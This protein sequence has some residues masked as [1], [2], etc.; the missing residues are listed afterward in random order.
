[1]SKDEYKRKIL[2]I[3]K[4]ELY[5]NGQVY[6]DAKLTEI[7]EAKLREFIKKAKD[8]RKLDIDDSIS[9]KK[10]LVK[11]KL[12]KGGNLT[13]SAVLLF[14]RNPQEFFIQSG[15]KCIRFKGMD[16]TGEMLDFKEIEGNLFSVIEEVENFVFKNIALKAWIEEGKIERQEKWEYPPKAIREVL[17]NAVVHRDYRSPSKVQVRIFDDRIEFWNPGR[18]PQGWTVET[19]K[20]E[21]T[22]EPFNPLIARMFFWIGYVEEVGTGTN[23]IIKWCREWELPEPEFRFAASSIVVTLRK[24][25]LTDEFIE[26]LGLDEREKEIIKTLILKGK[27]TSGEIQ[28]KFGVTR[29]T[30]NR[31]L[32]GF[33][34]LNLIERKGKGRFI[35][36]ILREK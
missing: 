26:K 8:V 25:K 7:D 36:Y 2:E 17:V 9:I 18:L 4:K 32:K 1:M 22:S 20:R 13:N 35:Y 34:D 10:A 23:K 5:F 33:I 6:F 14:G 27:I 3:H 24:S 12:M 29:D 31:L 15:V 19:L 21:H 30:A 28:K 16:V 11:L